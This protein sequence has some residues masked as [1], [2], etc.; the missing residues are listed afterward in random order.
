MPKVS[1]VTDDGRSMVGRDAVSNCG[2]D[3]AGMVLEKLLP[4]M[5]ESNITEIGA[6]DENWKKN[7]ILRKFYQREFLDWKDRLN[8][9]IWT[10]GLDN[11]GFVFYPNKCGFTVSCKVHV[12]LHGCGANFEL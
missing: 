4:N 1:C 8:P 2:F 11:Y 6:R 7:G 3:W 10:N 12:V 5:P 9:T